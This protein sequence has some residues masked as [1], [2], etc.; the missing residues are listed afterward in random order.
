MTT[1]STQDL[2]FMAHAIRLAA[3]G[4]FTTSPNPNV[5]CVIVKDGQVI[6]EGWHI[7]AGQGHAEVNALANLTKEQSSGATAY[8]TLEHV[9]I[10]AEHLLVQTD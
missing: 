9:V 2:I 3:R 1:T 7:K 4:Q 6:G 5:G 10:L 8:V